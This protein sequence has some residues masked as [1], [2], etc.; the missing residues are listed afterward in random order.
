MDYGYT[1]I[2][3]TRIVVTF[4]WKYARSNALDFTIL[5]GNV[6]GNALDFYHPTALIRSSSTPARTTRPVYRAVDTL[7]ADRAVRVDSRA[8]WIV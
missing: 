1:G 5:W 6:S 4:F 7:A 3:G 2:K 8:T